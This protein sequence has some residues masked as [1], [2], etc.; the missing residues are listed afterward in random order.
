MTSF[1]QE[2]DLNIEHSSGEGNRP[3]I[4]S[5]T[6]CQEEQVIGTWTS[7]PLTKEQATTVM[8]DGCNP[9]LITCSI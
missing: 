2:M 1:P 8:L 3:D 9:I 5:D 7:E 6:F 4:Q